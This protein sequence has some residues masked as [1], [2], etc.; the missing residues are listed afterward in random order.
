MRWPPTPRAPWPSRCIT[1]HLVGLKLPVET[2]L[3]KA[4]ELPE[5][6]LLKTWRTDTDALLAF[7][8]LSP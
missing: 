3:R 6:P 5:D 8:R 2:V 4:G 1:L 7:G